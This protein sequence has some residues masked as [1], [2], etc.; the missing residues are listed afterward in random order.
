MTPQERKEKHY[1]FMCAAIQGILANPTESSASIRD[2][3][4][5]AVDVANASLAAYE[6]GWEEDNSSKQ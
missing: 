1:G 6:A 2:V 4:I 5:G 3:V